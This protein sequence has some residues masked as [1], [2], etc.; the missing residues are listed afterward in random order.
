MAVIGLESY[1]RTLAA[2]TGVRGAYIL[3]ST[4]LD[5][6]TAGYTT[7]NELVWA[8]KHRRIIVAATYAVFNRMNDAVD[9]KRPVYHESYLQ[10]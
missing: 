10:S 1:K 3:W 4:T 2:Y 6:N 8:T 5:S 9:D 7:P